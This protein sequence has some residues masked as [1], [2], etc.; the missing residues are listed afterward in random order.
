MNTACK[1][2][3][4]RDNDSEAIKRDPFGIENAFK[5]LTMNHEQNLFQ[6]AEELVAHYAKYECGQYELSLSALPDYEQDELIRRYI[7]ATDREVNEC[8]YGDDF[9]INNEFTCALLSMLQENSQESR[10]RFAKTTR[11]NLL[12]YYKKS[13]ETLLDEACEA[14]SNNMMNE[15]GYYAYRDLEHGD[16]NWRKV[17]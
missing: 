10:E 12:T 11:N 17:G 14:F 9:T 3:I 15:Q 13:L 1:Y 2:D 5:G 4:L 16:I 6:F 7:E 8:I